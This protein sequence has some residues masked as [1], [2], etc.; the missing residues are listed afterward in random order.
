MSYKKLTMFQTLLVLMGNQSGNIR[1]GFNRN[2]YLH[3]DDP[4][5]TGGDDDK[6]PDGSYK[7]SFVEKLLREKNNWKKSA[8]DLKKELEDAKK[9]PAP[10]KD[11][12][13]P[14]P[15]A[16]AKYKE[17]L[18]AKDEDNKKIKDQLDALNKQ[19]EEGMK[20]GSLREEFEKL[21]G[22][23]KKFELI[24]R[25]CDT[26]KILIDEDSGVV[27]G[28]ETEV[29]RVKELAPELFGKPKKGVNDGDSDQN[30][31]HNASD[32]DAFKKGLEGARLKTKDG[33][34]PFEALYAAKGLTI[35]AKRN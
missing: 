21:G 18:R 34:N 29:K 35:S 19:K 25:L 7:A 20:A 13:N 9:T 27:Y 8:D 1:F 12:Q 5:G 17:L 11:D 3:P 6:N 26:N 15:D 33:K 14:N 31:T 24:K 23:P 28:A 32:D 16:D 22:D 30:N 4:G 2:R 10:K